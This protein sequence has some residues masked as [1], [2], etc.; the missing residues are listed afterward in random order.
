MEQQED[1]AQNTMKTSVNMGYHC[2]HKKSSTFFSLAT[3]LCLCATLN[4]EELIGYIF[5]LFFSSLLSL[6]VTYQQMVKA[7][8]EEFQTSQE[9]FV[10]L[11]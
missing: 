8:C 6:P 2:L 3:H 10:V 7:S 9:M 5:F 11:V 1:L 4:L